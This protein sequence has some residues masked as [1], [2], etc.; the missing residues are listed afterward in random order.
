MLF[1]KRFAATCSLL[2]FWL[3]YSKLLIIIAFFELLKA[4]DKNLIELIIQHMMY[5]ITKLLRIKAYYFNNSI[6]KVFFM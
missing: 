6:K 5:Y 4:C 2:N 3:H 1:E